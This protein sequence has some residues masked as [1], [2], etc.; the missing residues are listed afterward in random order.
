MKVDVG[1]CG[2]RRMPPLLIAF[3]VGLCWQQRGVIMMWMLHHPGLP[4]RVPVCGRHR[5]SSSDLTA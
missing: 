1:G 5:R 4:H 2:A 3:K